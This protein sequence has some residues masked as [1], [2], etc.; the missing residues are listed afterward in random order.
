MKK[1]II[2]GL[3]AGLAL[4]LLSSCSGNNAQTTQNSTLLTS[5]PATSVPTVPTS[6]VPPASQAPAAAT[7][8]VG[9]QAGNLAPD[10][11]LSSLDGKP[12]SL[13]D[14]RGKPVWLNFWATW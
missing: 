11:Q 2:L 9:N 12:V 10:F 8:K 6:S 4:V 7:P 14:F 5:A 3:V 13:S 1:L